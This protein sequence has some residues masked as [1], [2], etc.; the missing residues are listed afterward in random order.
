MRYLI[1]RG[2]ILVIDCLALPFFSSNCYL[3]ALINFLAAVGGS[4]IFYIV[5][6]CKC[7]MI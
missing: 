1:F 5:L 6:E 7:Y 3:A 2:E 4:L